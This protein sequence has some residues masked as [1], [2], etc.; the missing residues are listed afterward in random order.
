MCLLEAVVFLAQQV[1]EKA[2]WNG[3][4]NKRKVLAPC[5]LSLQGAL[6][7]EGTR[8]LGTDTRPALGM[9]CSVQEKEKNVFGNT[10]ASQADVY[11]RRPFHLLV[12][13]VVQRSAYSQELD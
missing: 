6:C 7:Q 3:M 9:E 11:P 1:S 13:G 2:K 4:R 8:A 10:N 5:T 12:Q